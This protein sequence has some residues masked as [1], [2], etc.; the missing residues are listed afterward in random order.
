[1][2]YISPAELTA[3]LGGTVTAV[4]V[5][6]TLLFQVREAKNKKY[7]AERMR[8]ELDIVRKS[9]EEQIYRLTERM[10]STN[11]KWQDANHL[12]LSGQRNDS[13]NESS[14]PRIIPQLEFLEK[15]G[16]D[17]AT[18]IDKKLIFVLT[19]FHPDFDKLYGEIRHA[20]QEVG[21]VCMRGDEEFISGDLL[22]HILKLIVRARLIIA[23][24]DGRNPNVFYELGM[25]HI[26]GKQVLI[27]AKSQEDIPFD[28]RSNRILFYTDPEE[29]RRKLA[30]E[31]TKALLSER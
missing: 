21:L 2:R 12:V 13:W 7:D 31:L 5:I 26:L 23:V 20:C 24:V 3:I 27:V 9:L 6:A 22:P 1:M 10:T 16:V 18:T 11:Q 14:K 4:T 29:I 8:A 15:A 30:N 28:I 17:A 19:P 25:A